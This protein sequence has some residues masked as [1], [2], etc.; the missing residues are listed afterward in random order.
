MG[1]SAM[2][3]FLLSAILLPVSIF[4]LALVVPSG[5]CAAAHS[6]APKVETYLVITITDENKTENQVEYKAIATSQY[7]AEE[8]RVKDDNA[9]KMKE[10]K[11]LK[12]TTPDAPAPKKIIIKKIPKLTGYLIQKDAQEAADK[13]KKEAA[14]NAAP[15]TDKDAKK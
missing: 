4:A 11:D 5:A 3:K 13:L 7:K 14:D 15:K 9:T 2:K 8:K 6:T 12:K 1:T 10:W